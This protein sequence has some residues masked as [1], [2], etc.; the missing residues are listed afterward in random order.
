MEWLWSQWQHVEESIRR[1]R[2]ILLFLDYDG[3]LTPIAPSPEQATLPA[4]TRSLLR[5][6]SC[7]SRMTVAL[8]SGRA[9]DELRRLVG[10]RKPIY[11]GNHG[12]EVWRRGRRTSVVVSGRFRKAVAGIRPRLASLAAD[13]PGAILE[14]KRLSLSLHYRM[15]PQDQVAHLKAAFRREVLPLVHAAELTVLHGKKVIEVRPRVNWTKGHAALWL[16]TRMRRR[17]LLPIYIGDDRT[18][19]DAF[20]ALKGG[21]TIRVGADRRSKARF[22]VRD[23]QEALAFL[24][25][26]TALCARGPLPEDRLASG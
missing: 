24:Q 3:T 19:E 11:V 9:L 17:S 8:I 25:W 12:L 5:T 21:I 22:Y 13:S 10:L 2:H 16:V 6:L 4:S 15:V 23:I 20:A 26:V 1:S 7:H 14:D 18:D